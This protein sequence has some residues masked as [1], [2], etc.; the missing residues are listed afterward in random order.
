MDYV[1]I[2]VVLQCKLL[3]TERIIVV[4]NGIQGGICPN[5]ISIVYNA[6]E[7]SQIFVSMRSTPYMTKFFEE[8]DFSKTNLS[9]G[10]HLNFYW[11]DY[12]IV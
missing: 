3:L 2:L 11:A 4:S 7:F 5:C 8:D 1:E 12:T 10:K 9:S 6:P